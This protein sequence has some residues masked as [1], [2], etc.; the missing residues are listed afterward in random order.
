MQSKLTKDKTKLIESNLLANKI[1]GKILYI[2]SDKLYN[3]AI[4]CLDKITY[5]QKY[6]Y[7]FIP[8]TKLR[9]KARLYQLDILFCIRKKLIFSNYIKAKERI[10]HKKTIKVIF[11]VNQNQK[12]KCDSLYK[13]LEKDEYFEPIIVVLPLNNGSNTIKQQLQTN[14]NFFRSKKMKNLVA[15]DIGRD[16]HTGLI[17]YKP[18]IIFYQQPWHIYKLDKIEYTSRYALTCYVPYFI[19]VTK[20]DWHTYHHF[21]KLLWRFFTDFKLNTNQL[22]KLYDKKNKTLVPSGHPNLDYYC[23]YKIKP[24]GEIK[25]II[26]APHHSFEQ[27]QNSLKLAT[28]NWSGDPILEFARNNPEINFILKPHPRFKGAIIQNGIRTKEQIED[29]FTA[30]ES[31]DNCQ[32]YDKGDYLDLFTASDLLITDCGSF[33]VEYLFTGSPV[34]R[35]ASKNNVGYNALGNLIIQ[36][37]YTAEDKDQLLMQLQRIITNGEDPLREKRLECLKS[38]QQTK[39]S[40]MFIK[41][42]LKNEL[43]IRNS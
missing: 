7:R 42:Y 31:L 20:D 38:L 16:N 18:D 34:I 25:K 3:A 40:G 41:D 26:F 27:V 9:R 32:I 2:K 43:R 39:S 5:F 36:N 37:Y 22:K 13:E 12:W 8:I 30:W 15:I 28:F 24:P 23:E 11:L 35:L 6:I 1:R 17:S 21:H 33:L 4:Y 29:Y 10:A 14:I 19:S